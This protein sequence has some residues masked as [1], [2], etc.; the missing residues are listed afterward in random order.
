VTISARKN[1][2]ATKRISYSAA[3]T[4]ERYAKTRKTREENDAT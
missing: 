4:Y 3:E 1:S 2:L